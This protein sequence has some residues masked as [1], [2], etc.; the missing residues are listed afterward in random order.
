MGQN[1]RYGDPLSSLDRPALAPPAA[2]TRPQHV[3]VN[4]STLRHRTGEYPGLLVEWRRTASSW[5]A[6]C[7]WATPEGGVHENWVPAEQLRPVLPVAVE[8]RGEREH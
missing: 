4:L 1:R 3:W 2:V 8:N 6:R 7:F 5:E